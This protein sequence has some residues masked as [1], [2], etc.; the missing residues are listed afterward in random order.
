M[1]E[2]WSAVASAVT[3]SSCWLMAT[4]WSASAADGRQR[5]RDVGRDR[6]VDRRGDVGVGRHRAGDRRRDV[7]VDADVGVDVQQVAVQQGLGARRRCGHA[8]RA[9][10]RRHG[11]GRAAIVDDVIAL[12]DHRGLRRVGDRLAGDALVDRSGL[13]GH[14]RRLGP[15][16]QHV[17]GDGGVDR[18]RD[19]RVGRNRQ[20]DRRGQV[21]RRV[22]VDVQVEQRNDFLV[23]QRRAGLGFEVLAG[24]T[25]FVAHGLLRFSVDVSRGP[26]AHDPPRRNRHCADRVNASGVNGQPDGDPSGS[27]RQAA[28]HA[29]SEVGHST[30]LPVG[31]DSHTQQVS[32]SEVARQLR[33]PSTAARPATTNAAA[34]SAHHQPTAAFRPSPTRTTPDRTAH[35]WVCCASR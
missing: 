3:S 14:R 27:R 9:V 35:S 2:S 34:G 8:A 33:T 12:V 32:S 30:R 21:E 20:V 11:N 18:G 15:E 25:R 7:G 24:K 19:V 28:H 13:R 6:R 1:V 10:G 16:R 4:S 17:R 23:R 5:R 29:E 22:Q 26:A 31:I